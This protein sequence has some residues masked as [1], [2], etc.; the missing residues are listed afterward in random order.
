[1]KLFINLRKWHL[2]LSAGWYNGEPFAV[3]QLAIGQVIE[4]DTLVLF[5]IQ[6]ARFA[7]SFGVDRWLF[8]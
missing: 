2:F 5:D 8:R 1:M 3:F 4:P 7:L 6:V